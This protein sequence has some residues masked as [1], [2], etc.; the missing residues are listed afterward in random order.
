M[1]EALFVL[2]IVQVERGAVGIDVEIRRPAETARNR[3]KILALEVD[4]E[5]LP[6]LGQDDRADAGHVGIRVL[7]RD[8]AD[9]ELLDP[10][11]AFVAARPERELLRTGQ[12]IAARTGS[13]VVRGVLPVD[14]GPAG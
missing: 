13:P 3:G 8:A 11:A 7:T 4:R 2:E 14:A 12:I 1:P 10:F 9:L 6:F 5:L